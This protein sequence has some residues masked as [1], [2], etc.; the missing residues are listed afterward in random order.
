ML[1]SVA[2]AEQDKHDPKEIPETGIPA[3]ERAPL[4]GD[5]DV[6]DVSYA[7]MAGPDGIAILRAEASEGYVWQSI[8]TLPAKS[9]DSE[10]W[11][12]NSCIDPGGT[13]MA[14]VYGPRSFTNDEANFL[15]G[16]WGA[17]VNLDSGDVTDLGRG[18]SLAYFNPGCGGGPFAAFLRYTDE[19]T[20][21]LATV[22]MRSGETVRKADVEGEITSPATLANGDVIAASGNG[23]VRV[24]EAGKTEKIRSTKGMPYRLKIDSE[25]Q[26]GYMTVDSN[27]TSS[28][29]VSDHANLAKANAVASGPLTTIG[30]ERAGGTIYVLG[31]A[32]PANS[33]Q[34]G[35]EFLKGAEVDA[36]LS[37]RGALV[38]NSVAPAGV[39]N[40]GDVSSADV[41]PSV[42]TWVP[43]TEQDLRFLVDP[44]NDA[45]EETSNLDEFTVAPDEAPA[46]EPAGLSVRPL[47]VVNMGSPT[48]PVEDERTCAVPRNDPHNQAYQPKPRQVQWAV[49]RAVSG[50]L[51][52]QRPANWRNLG[53]PAYTAQGLFPRVGLTGGGSI[54]PQIVLGVLAQESNLWQASRYTS[55]GSTGNPLI[56]DF[57]GSRPE[58]HEPDSA[59][60]DIDFADAD[61]GYGVGQITD[62]MRLAGRERPGETALPYDKQRAIAL[63]YTANVAMAVRMLGQKWNEVK[64]AG[65]DINNGDPS[66]IENWF[67]AVWAYNTGFYPHAGAGQPWGV[68]W[69]N[70]PI[71]PIYPPNRGPFLD[72]DPSDAATPQLWPYPEKVLGFAAHALDL[73]LTTMADP[74]SRTYPTTYVSAFTTAWWPGADDIAAENNRRQVKP[75]ITTFCSM[76][77][78][79]CNPSASSPCTL[80]GEPKC[81]WHADSVWKADCPNTCGQGEERFDSSY[82]TESSAMGSTCRR[83]R[84][85]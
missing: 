4:I 26:L 61:C 70:N 17:I 76:G 48:N 42:R 36:K 14:V 1:K 31:E 43:A 30:I 40:S 38:I 71:N 84:S 66:Y 33:H 13:H 85:N 25:D 72:G 9:I 55:P 7:T 51:T 74:A 81:W 62:G 52:E 67:F 59:L 44:S 75:P 20:T 49:D 47:T 50:Q 10:L 24:G 58:G 29:W 45:D 8:A 69:F 12:A 77:V 63:D 22:D 54:P 65:M 15:G 28:V 68:G 34:A 11:V 37:V 16:A 19:G 32:T 27:E 23:I 2:K 80:S 57:Y 73:P 39:A 83:Q 6:A 53:M 18:Q 78:N 56:G 21:Q 60:W 46:S 82:S 41:R 3:E 35:I 5:A 79:D 64:A